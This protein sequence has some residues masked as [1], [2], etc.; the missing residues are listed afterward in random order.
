MGKLSEGGVVDN[1][2]CKVLSV[3]D[4][5]WEKV[6]GGAKKIDAMWEAAEHFSCT[7]EY[8]RKGV[9]HYTDVNLK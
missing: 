5:V 9:Y 1:T 3:R 7:K 8:V 4:Y 6:K 2:L